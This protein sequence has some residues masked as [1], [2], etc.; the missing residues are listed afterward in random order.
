MN[1]VMFMISAQIAI[2]MVDKFF[3]HMLIWA[4]WIIVILALVPLVRLALATIICKHF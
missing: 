4:I 2:T 1:A 3:P